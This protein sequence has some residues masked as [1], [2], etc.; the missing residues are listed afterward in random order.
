VWGGRGRCEELGELGAG[1]L[2]AARVGMDGEVASTGDA[3]RDGDDD[4]QWWRL[5]GSGRRGDEMAR[6]DARH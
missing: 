4:A 1:V 2:S 3:C 6:A 5:D